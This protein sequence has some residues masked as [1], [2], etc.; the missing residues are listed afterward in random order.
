MKFNISAVNKWNLAAVGIVVV[1]IAL[2]AYMWLDTR[3]LERSFSDAKSDQAKS[4]RSDILT[5]A[6]STEPENHGEAVEK[7]P[8]SQPDPAEKTGE[9]E[10]TSEKRDISRKGL[11]DDWMFEKG[12]DIEDTDTKEKPDKSGESK[13]LPT[14]E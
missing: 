8:P 11:T 7:S 6:S 5:S 13:T 9:Q 1:V 2:V 10:E 3:R 4:D 12:A 14:S